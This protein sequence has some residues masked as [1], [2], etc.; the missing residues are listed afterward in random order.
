VRRH[1]EVRGPLEHVQVLGLLGELRDELD[2]GRARAD[3]A[4][5]LA[6]EVDAL[7][8]PARAVVPLALEVVEAVD[9]R[10]VR[11]R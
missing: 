1:A 2:A 7:V 3:H 5:A 8:R 11:D 6:G 9:R 10:A 4:D